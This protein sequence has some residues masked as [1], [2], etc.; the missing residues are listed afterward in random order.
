MNIPRGGIPYV[1]EDGDDDNAIEDASILLPSMMEYIYACNGGLGAWY[2]QLLQ[3]LNIDIFAGYWMNSSKTGFGTGINNEACYTLVHAYDDAVFGGWKSSMNPFGIIRVSG[4]VYPNGINRAVLGMGYVTKVLLSVRAADAIGT[5]P[6]T[7]FGKENADY[8][9]LEVIYTTFFHELDSALVYLD[10]TKTSTQGIDQTKDYFYAGNQQQWMKLA[11]SLRLRLAMR[12]SKVDPVKAK[13]QAQKAINAPGGLI[14]DN[15]DNAAFR[16][17]RGEVA[18]ATMIAWG[19]CSVDA[20]IHSILAGYED[21]RLDVFMEKTDTTKG[22]Q[23][24]IIPLGRYVSQRL[25]TTGIHAAPSAQVYS[26]GGKGIPLGVP[27]DVHPEAST[28]FNA[29]ETHFL[30]AE[31]RLRDFSS[32]STAKQLY[33]EGIT[34]SMHQWKWAKEISIDEINSYLTNTKRP[35]DYTDPATQKADINAASTCTV[36]WDDASN[37]EAR[38]EKIITQKWLAMWPVNSHEAWSEYRR[39]G[40]PKMFPAY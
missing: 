31:A 36:S 33:E 20:N 23:E 30:L 22:N 21:P 19:S 12:L 1:P 40:Y 2:Y 6:Y 27:P 3:N 10:Q 39:T 35:A 5:L 18:I 16:F 34:Q 15:A 37:D 29:A 7:S 26:K 24:S 28:F 4:H 38:L 11:N 17:P 25:G 13:F 9:G 32:E 14:R 8:D